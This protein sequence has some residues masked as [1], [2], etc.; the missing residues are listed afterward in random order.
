MSNEEENV[1][2]FGVYGT[3]NIQKK[4]VYKIIMW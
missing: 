3:V 2:D 4:I 1:K